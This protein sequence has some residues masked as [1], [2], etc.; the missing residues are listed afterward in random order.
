MVYMAMNDV[1]DLSAKSDGYEQR[2]RIATFD[3][4]N[5][6][7]GYVKE[8][9]SG[10]GHSASLLYASN[11]NLYLG[12][13]YDASGSARWGLA[14][15]RI[16]SSGVDVDS[17]I[18]IL[19]FTGDNGGGDCSNDLGFT[20]TTLA[21]YINHIGYDGVKN[22]MFGTSA[23]NNHAGNMQGKDMIIFTVVL[24]SNGDASTAAGDLKTTKITGWNDESRVMAVH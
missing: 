5:A 18:S 21:P 16:G 9:S 23:T 19:H 8:Q 14:F 20:D 6:Q 7:L 3:Y 2:L 15:V 17:K 4:P 13:S 22:K 11:N 1:G 10:Y 24:D 12:G